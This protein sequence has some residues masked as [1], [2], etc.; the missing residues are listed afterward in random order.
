MTTKCSVQEISF[1]GQIFAQM[2]LVPLWQQQHPIGRAGSSVRRVFAPPLWSFDSS[3]QPLSCLGLGE[4]IIIE[5]SPFYFTG[6]YFSQANLTENPTSTLA[7]RRL[8]RQTCS[9]HKRSEQ[10]KS[11]LHFPFPLWPL[12]Y[13]KTK[14]NQGRCKFQ[15][16]AA[17]IIQCRIF[18]ERGVILL[19]EKSPGKRSVAGKMQW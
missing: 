19:R 15:R 18:A 7:G 6:P 8:L 2:E 9:H 3:L 14:K 10:W 17:I 13:K 1:G 4:T 11:A 16:A 5:S 12:C